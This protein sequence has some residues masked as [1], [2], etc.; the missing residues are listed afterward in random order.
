MNTE[1]NNILAFE[2]L[3]FTMSRFAAIGFAF[4]VLIMIGFFSLK[5]INFQDSTNVKFSELSTPS[6]SPSSSPNS[7]IAPPAPI[8]KIYIPE[9]V[10]E[11][12][13]ADRLIETLN[14]HISSLDQQQDYVENMSEVLRE[15]K[16]NNPNIT[17]D[18]LFNVVNKYTRLKDSKMASS[19]AEQ[20]IEM[21]KKI[22]YVAGIFTMMFLLT[23][24]SMVLV[25]LSIE[26]N[27]RK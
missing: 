23:M 16:S 13:V 6:V 5:L 14:N 12:I 27:T 18:E 2:K 17:H 19:G 7:T 15:A 25:L 1:S 8:S 21:A 10:R 22:G 4:V 11:I 9:N 20:Y 24:V 26:R 3:C